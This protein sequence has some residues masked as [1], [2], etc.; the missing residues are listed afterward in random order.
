MHTLIM[1]RQFRTL[2]HDFLWLYEASLQLSADLR[3]NDLLLD[4]SLIDS[5]ERADS[6]AHES[7]FVATIDCRVDSCDTLKIDHAERDILPKHNE[8]H[9]CLDDV[10]DERV[11]L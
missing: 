7:S 3:M 9:K 2:N 1:Y 11:L 10:E 8:Y 4:G 6:S 5:D